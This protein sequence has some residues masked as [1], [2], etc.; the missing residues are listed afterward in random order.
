[1]VSAEEIEDSTIFELEKNQTIFYFTHFNNRESP[2]FQL[3]STSGEVTT[4]KEECFN[5]YQHMTVQVGRDIY[6]FGWNPLQVF[7]YT[8]TVDEHG[9][10]SM[11]KNLE[12]THEH[13]REEFALALDSKRKAIYVSG[14]DVDS[15]RSKSVLCFSIEAQKFTRAPDM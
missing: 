4:R 7:R 2:C 13:R 11:V 8:E 9:E 14:G 6:S 10:T 3:D 5:F 12:A 15:N 1:M